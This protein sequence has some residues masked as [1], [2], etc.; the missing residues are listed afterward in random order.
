[1]P[2]GIAWLDV[3]S[4]EQRRAREL[5]ELFTQHESRDELGIG[6]IRDAFSDILFPGTSVLQTRA[7]YL[8]FVP[9]VFQEGQRLGY[10][11]ARLAAWNDGAERRLIETLRAA[12]ATDGLIGVRAGVAIGTLPS[13]IYWGALVR[14]GI[15]TRDLAPDQL[16][17]YRPATRTRETDELAERVVGDWHPMPAPPEGFPGTVDSG[18]TLSP[19][20]S[21]WLSERI[22]TEAPGTLLSHL[23]EGDIQPLD[24]SDG[25]WSDPACVGAI[26]EVRAHLAQAHLFSLGMEGAT[27][28]YNLIVREHYERAGLNRVESSVEA[29]R[30]DLAEWAA[31]CEDHMHDFRAWDRREMWDL[32]RHRNPRISLP[33]QL[34]VDGWL[35]TVVQ[36]QAGRVADDNHARALVAN[37]ER[38]QKGSQSRLVNDRL[39]RTW[40]GV[41]GVGLR[42]RWP[43]VRRLVNDMH[44]GRSSL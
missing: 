4:E 24:D 18:F 15:L 10:A 40:S 5:I 31:R 26:P 39:L 27:H 25:P 17:P 13:T 22:A 7:R 14:W 1:M 44:E 38:R 29:Y 42:Y 3:S 34:F 30:Q 16:L 35:D 8:L 36:G 28:L 9:W 11:G 21:E 32:V 41:S 6:Q 20:E 37:R 33:T 43:N 23:V 12:G 2:S 19:E